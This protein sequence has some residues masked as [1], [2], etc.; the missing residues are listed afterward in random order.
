MG[1]NFCC[2]FFFFGEMYFIL[3]IGDRMKRFLYVFPLL[4]AFLLF[5]YSH[6]V[7]SKTLEEH[8]YLENMMTNIGVSYQVS[9]RQM[10]NIRQDFLS[11]QDFFE[12]A[13]GDI[14]TTYLKYYNILERIDDRMQN[15]SKYM[16]TLENSCEKV[17][18]YKNVECDSYTEN[19]SL[20]YTDYQRLIQKYNATILQYNQ[21][22]NTN[23]AGFEVES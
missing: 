17:E 22:A 23:L 14:E 2:P 5:F 12:Q 7:Y 13:P 1:D 8:E 21:Y 20:I 15:L 18:E 16:K 11:M 4:L 6:Q 3:I 10:K 19:Y 9:V